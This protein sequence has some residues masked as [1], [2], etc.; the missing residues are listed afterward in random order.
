MRTCGYRAVRADSKFAEL[1]KVLVTSFVG[2]EDLIELMASFRTVRERKNANRDRRIVRGALFWFP[3]N[4]YGEPNGQPPVFIT[5]IPVTGKRL[6]E[7]G[8]KRMQ[9]LRD[10]KKP[11]N[12]ILTDDPFLL[13]SEFFDKKVKLVQSYEGRRNQDAGDRE[14]DRSEGRDWEPIRF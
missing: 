12:R 10:Q 2:N 5:K 9:Y 11:L 13:S 4:K 1:P 6:E 3:C 8:W 14:E 7:K